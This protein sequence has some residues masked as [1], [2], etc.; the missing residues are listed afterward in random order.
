MAIV[1]LG[2][3][4]TSGLHSSP[5]DVA[6]TDEASTDAEPAPQPPE[7]PRPAES[8][9]GAGA[10]PPEPPPPVS[11]ESRPIELNAPKSPATPPETLP[12]EQPALPPG[13]PTPAVPA[14][15]TDSAPP[16]V[17]P[18][19]PTATLPGFSAGMSPPG[20]EPPGP[21]ASP[22]QFE[23]P[24][25]APGGTSGP[26]P[27]PETPATSPAIVTPAPRPSGP[28][29]TTQPATPAKQAAFGQAVAAVRN[30]MGVRDLD[31]AKGLLDTAA[32]SAETDANSAEIG[33]LR[34][35]H[36]NLTEFW[37]GIREGV[38]DLNDV[39]DIPLGDT[40]IAI[41]ESSRD[42]IVLR[43]AGRNKRFATMELPTS[44]VIYIADRWFS[45]KAASSKVLIGSFLAVDPKGD[46]QR[47]RELWQQATKEGL[48]CDD[49]M[50]ELDRAATGG[51]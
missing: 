14:L 17:D 9:P 33:R 50:P 27:G 49:L 6:A 22:F 29:A 2:G 15:T 34:V 23:T 40:R 11:V 18:S 45:K 28:A 35:L 51:P 37:S 4:L 39:G 12:P 3:I 21:E 25:A 38:A 24:A 41:V 42:H 7:P 26:P 32:Q 46:R 5:T 48:S 44:F 1:I 43:A 47:A 36:H 20:V 16:V 30:A 19:L 31:G 10:Q 13:P 8:S